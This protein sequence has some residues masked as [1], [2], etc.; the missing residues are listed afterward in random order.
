MSKPMSNATQVVSNF[1]YQRQ[2]KQ[3]KDAIIVLRL[4]PTLTLVAANDRA[5]QMFDG[6]QDWPASGPDDCQDSTFAEQILVMTGIV[7]DAQSSPQQR[8]CELGWIQWDPFQYENTTYAVLTIQSGHESMTKP[9]AESESMN[10]MAVAYWLKTFIHQVS[11]PL[12]VNQNTADILQIEA[13]QNKIDPQSI[14][15]RL[16][17]M[18]FAGNLLREC[19]SDLRKQIQFMSL[20]FSPIKIQDLVSDVVSQFNTRHCTALN[21]GHEALDDNVTIHGNATLLSEGISSILDLMWE[22]RRKAKNTPEHPAMQPCLSLSMDRDD[23]QIQIRITGDLPPANSLAFFDYPLMK[24]LHDRLIPAATWGVCESI[25]QA[26][27]GDLSRETTGEAVQI[28]IGLPEATERT[29][30]PNV[31]VALHRVWPQKSGD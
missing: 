21:L 13:E 7:D 17:R 8:Q 24:Q 20:E 15:P 16:E 11:Q 19:L 23:G 25:L 14:Q 3:S 26:H 31:N 28:R 22:L 4:Q 6:H 2:F 18:Q 1:Y 30:Q 5:R 27:Y 12:H 9:P 29:Q 10:A